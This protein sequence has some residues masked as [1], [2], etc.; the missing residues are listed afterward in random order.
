M[1]GTF[2]TDL[3]TPQEY[4][5][6]RIAIAM[7]Q[8][9]LTENYHKL[10]VQSARYDRSL[11]ERVHAKELE[12]ELGAWCRRANQLR[13][14]GDDVGSIIK[15]LIARMDIMRARGHVEWSEPPDWTSKL[16]A[17]TLPVLEAMEAELRRPEES[18]LFRRQELWLEWIDQLH[19]LWAKF[20]TV[21]QAQGVD[22]HPPAL[23]E[24]EHEAVQ[25]CNRTKDKMYLDES[26]RWLTWRTFASCSNICSSAGTTT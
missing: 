15:R 5:H 1:T 10:R 18:H 16:G 23:F 3:Q 12:T 20:G 24:S 9:V 26:E 4:F 6:N 14:V 19:D 17:L 21:P 13:A 25:R 7:V 2:C 22:P 11:V 8:T